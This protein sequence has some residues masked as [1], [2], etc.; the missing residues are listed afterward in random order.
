MSQTDYC[1]THTH[2]HTHTQTHTHT[3]LKRLFVLMLLKMVANQLV[4]QAWTEVC[5][6]ILGGWELKTM[7]NWQKNVCCVWV[8]I[9]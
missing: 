9:F 4:I 3:M 6:Q 5:H 8:Y 7:W 2:T 1:F